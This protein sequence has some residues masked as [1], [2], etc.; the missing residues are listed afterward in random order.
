MRAVV[1]MFV[2]L[3]FPGFIVVYLKKNVYFSSRVWWYTVVIPTIWE[4]E[5]GGSRCEARPGKA[6]IRPYLK[7]IEK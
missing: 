2:I 5:E 1:K 4:S 3:D 6:S 7:N